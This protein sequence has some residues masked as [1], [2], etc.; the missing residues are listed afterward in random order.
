VTAVKTENLGFH[1]LFFPLPELPPENLPVGVLW[2]G[3]EEYNFLRNELGRQRLPQ[4]ACQGLGGEALPLVCHHKGGKRFTVS[5]RDAHH[6]A[7]ADR[8]MGCQSLLDLPW[9]ENLFRQ[10]DTLAHSAKNINM[11]VSIGLDTASSI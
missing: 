2:Q 11:S 4:K 8:R 7:L 6:G 3:V 1:S 9:L 5:V 10:V